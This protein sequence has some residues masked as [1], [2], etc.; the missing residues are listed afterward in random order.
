VQHVQLLRPLLFHPPSELLCLP[1]SLRSR[2]SGVVT[3]FHGFVL[4]LVK[5]NVGVLRQVQPSGLTNNSVLTNIFYVVLWLLCP[6]LARPPPTGDNGSSAS[7]PP[8]SPQHSVGRE[9]RACGGRRH[10]DGRGPNWPS[11][12]RRGR[13]A[14][15]TCS[16]PLLPT[17]MSMDAT[18]MGRQPP[19]PNKG[20]EPH[21]SAQ[22]NSLWYFPVR[23]FVP[24]HQPV[25]AAHDHY[26]GLNRVGGLISEAM[27]CSPS[28]AELKPMDMTPFAAKIAA[29]C[30]GVL[31]CG[32]CDQPYITAHFLYLGFSRASGATAQAP[33]QRGSGISACQGFRLFGFWGGTRKCMRE[34]N[35]LSMLT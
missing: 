32:Y 27:K 19:S 22:I 15:A 13:C 31:S 2:H 7:S 21:Q 23:M 16:A 34:Q 14:A 11:S 3:A 10:R 1:S 25:D 20:A 28:K 33:V 12:P 5:R 18:P 9:D 17:S 24:T 6:A 26:L 35:G 4:H 30:L 8:S 29:A